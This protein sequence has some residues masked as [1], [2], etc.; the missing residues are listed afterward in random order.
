MKRWVLITALGLLACQADGSPTGAMAAG[1]TGESASE[2]AAEAPE[3]AH[4]TRDCESGPTTAPRP[5]AECEPCSAC[6]CDNALIEPGASHEDEGTSAEPYGDAGPL[7][8]VSPEDSATAAD[9]SGPPGM[10]MDAG[11]ACDCDASPGPSPEQPAP[12]SVRQPEYDGDGALLRPNDAER[13]VFMGSGVNL[14]Y[15]PV[16]PGVIVDVV[17]VTLMEPTAYRYF[18][19]HG[20]FAEG[21]MTV[22]MGFALDSGA[23]PAEH[24]QYPGDQ[25]FFEM[26]VKDS[27]AHGDAIWGYY[28]FG[29]GAGGRTAVAKPVAE[30]NACHAENAAEDFVFTQ[31]YPFMRSAAP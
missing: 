15:A 19:A 27:S 4:A 10:G 25:L 16:R 2:P 28:D 26:S 23:P 29:L 21:T 3:G 13:W 9:A 18:Q 20:T 5:G 31:F 14:N 24:G 6:E 17:T 22:L 1:S 30:C 8:A 7:E 11:V 12:G